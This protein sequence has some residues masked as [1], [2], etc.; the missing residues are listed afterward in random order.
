M[1]Q[2]SSQNPMNQTMSFSLRIFL[3]LASVAILLLFVRTGHELI[4]ATFLAY[5]IIIVAGPLLAWLSSKKVPNW[6]AF[7]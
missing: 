6:L 3:G 5:I 4:N 2:T 1:G 7:F